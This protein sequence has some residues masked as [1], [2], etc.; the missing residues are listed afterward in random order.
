MNRRLAEESD[1]LP[2]KRYKTADTRISNSSKL[3]RDFFSCKKTSPASS[4]QS[5][6]KGRTYLPLV[7][8]GSSKAKSL[9]LPLSM[10]S[11]KSLNFE[12]TFRPSSQE[13]WKLPVIGG[14]TR[15]PESEKIKRVS[16]TRVQA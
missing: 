8:L 1:A 3:P 16:R 13:K 2:P 4:C 9:E 15:K 6:K 11:E 12:I 5:G 14:G 7:K 10:L